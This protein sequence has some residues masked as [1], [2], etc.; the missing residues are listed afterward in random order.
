METWAQQLTAA[1]FLPY[2]GIL[3]WMAASDIREFRIPNA[4]NL[5]LF[6]LFFPTALILPQEVN[7][8]HHG[9]A[10]LLIFAITTGFWMLGWFGGG[11]VK[12]FTALALWAGL[13]YLMVMMFTISL[14]GGL[15]AVVIVLLRRFA[16]RFC[17]SNE[18]SQEIVWPKWL[19]GRPSMPYGA[20][21]TCG[22]IIAGFHSPL[23][24]PLFGPLF[25]P[26][27]SFLAQPFIGLFAG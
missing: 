13:P 10:A 17:P 26:P 7:W 25:P 24:Q 27:L 20:A 22:A 15:L 6:L 1:A 5:T 21:I 16:P 4:A 23:F 2:T 8:L 12:M 11:D 19:N 14:M 9:G 3:I 18:V